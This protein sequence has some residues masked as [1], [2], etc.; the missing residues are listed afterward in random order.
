MITFVKIDEHP[1]AI[2]HGASFHAD[3]I[4][5]MVILEKIYKTLS[6]CRITYNQESLLAHTSAIVFDVGNGKFDHHQKGGNGFHTLINEQKKPIPNASFGLLWNHYGIKVLQNFGIRKEAM[7]NYLFKYVEYH[8]VRS[9]DSSDNGLFPK[10]SQN[11]GRI[12]S[13]SAIISFLNQDSLLRPSNDNLNKALHLAINFAR[14]TLKVVIMNGI[15]AYEQELDY[16]EKFASIYNSR[17]EDILIKIISSEFGIA[18]TSETG[19]YTYIY[20]K[21]SQKFQ[22]DFEDA[23]NYLVGYL[24]GLLF[25]SIGVSKL[26][27]LAID[28]DTLDILTIADVYNDE[29]NYYEELSALVHQIIENLLFNVNY[30]MKSK[31]LVEN[32]LK[33]QNGKHILVFDEK[34]YWQ[35]WVAK[36]TNSKKV[37]FVV[38]PSENA[39]KIQPVPCK[40]NKN[41]FRKG[42]PQKWYG[43]K[44]GDVNK[45]IPNDI[46][47]IHPQGFLA[48]SQTKEGA[49]QLCQKAFSNNENYEL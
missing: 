38:S 43:Y 46:A 40:Y 34:V 10:Y 35:D 48:I 4:F 17:F 42:F 14:R 16:K 26:Y 20:N 30:K 41:G 3:D 9:I 1:D 39:W 5:G 24:N 29:Q 44:S 49:I 27:T 23:N 37:W 11:T 31:H 13:I 2:T 22:D 33:E 6:V 32:A 12:P 45:A 36:S 18:S 47:F 21:C 25:D 8:L 19:V 7:L 15:R 28:Y